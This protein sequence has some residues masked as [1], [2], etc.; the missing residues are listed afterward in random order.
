MEHVSNISKQNLKDENSVSLLSLTKRKTKNGRN[1]RKPYRH[2]MVL[3]L[4]Q[5]YQPLKDQQYQINN[6]SLFIQ[7]MRLKQETEV[8]QS[9]KKRPHR[10][11]DQISSKQ[12]FMPSRKCQIIYRILAMTFNMLKI[13]A[14]RKSHL[15]DK[16]NLIVFGIIS[17]NRQT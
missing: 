11:L 2:L 16:H 5:C 13:S 9:K 7:G 4:T 8:D 12:Q 15:G 3:Y 14:F 1:V 17:M 10:N 6:K